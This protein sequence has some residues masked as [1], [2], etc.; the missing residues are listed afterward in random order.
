MFMEPAKLGA[1]RGQLGVLEGTDA[2]TVHIKPGAM[3][4]R[5]TQ[6]VARQHVAVGGLRGRTR[7][8]GESEV[9]RARGHASGSAS[10]LGSCHISDAAD[11][12]PQ[13]VALL[14]L[15]LPLARPAHDGQR[16]H[17]TSAAVA[18]WVPVVQRALWV[19]RRR[20]K[21]LMRQEG[22]RGWSAAAQLHA[23][24]AGGQA[25]PRS[26]PQTHQDVQ[27]HPQ[28]L[29]H[30]VACKERTGG[31]QLECLRACSGSHGTKPVL[32]H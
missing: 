2:R 5:L 31:Q 23:W 18:G 4:W 25:D 3:P 13:L 14:H 7:N 16:L 11:L 19:G 9:W 26:P 1:G 15:C 22:W 12:P 32:L 28:L 6:L 27:L 24:D 21:V 20:K 30:E 10:H 17:Q 8:V 29:R